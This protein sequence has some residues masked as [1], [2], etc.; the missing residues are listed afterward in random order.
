MLATLDKIVVI[1][2]L[3]TGSRVESH[4]LMML[5][6]LGICFHKSFTDTVNQHAPLVNLDFEDVMILGFQASCSRQ[7]WFRVG[8]ALSGSSE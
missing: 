5:I 6:W 1:I 7:D 3:F 2:L 8:L 4:C